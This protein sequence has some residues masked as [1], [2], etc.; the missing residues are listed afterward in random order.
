MEQGLAESRRQLDAKRGSGDLS[1]SSWEALNSDIEAYES[2]VSEDGDRRKEI[3]GF[4]ERADNGI[5][6]LED[7]IT[8]AQDVME[9]IS[10]WEPEDEDDEL[11]EESLWA[12]V[13]SHFHQFD[14]ISMGSR[15]GIQ[16]KETEQKLENVKTLI[17]GN[18]LKLVLPDGAKLSTETYDFGVDKPS[19][20]CMNE[21]SILTAP[22]ADR[23]YL[24]EYAA[25][26]MDYFGRGSFDEGSS[27]TGSGHNELEYILFNKDNDTD[28]LEAVVKRLIEIR[29]G[30]NLVYLY[31]DTAKRNE[32][33]ALAL[34]ITGAFGLTPLVTVATFMIISI[35]SLG[36]AVCDVRELLGGGRVP[37]MHNSETFSLSLTGLI[38]LTEDGFRDT[39]RSSDSGFKY[40]D[41]L[42]MLLFFTQDTEQDYRCMD[43]MQLNLRKSQ[44]DFQMDRLV[45]SLETTVR[46]KAEHVFSVLGMV[47]S[48][49]IDTGGSYNMSVATA[50]SY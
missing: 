22:L 13:R 41:Y 18:M 34:S 14:L 8:E 35:W 11:D 15:Y 39:G 3:T 42:R 6:F 20:T 30:L 19:E 9:Y 26:M 7:V 47:K 4:I 33:R 36:Q 49:G 43:I 40:I 37:I 21:S 2:Y 50:Y 29:T 44:S 23:L 31:S 24:A 16:D 10:N 28:N 48:Q 27:R 38:G 32:A 5:S 46:V 1:D 45:Y 12:P 25:Q 17:N